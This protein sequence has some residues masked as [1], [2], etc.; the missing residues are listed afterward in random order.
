MARSFILFALFL[1]ERK[2]LAIL[3]RVQYNSKCK[4]TICFVVDLNALLIPGTS[5]CGIKPVFLGSRDSQLQPYAL[6][7]IH[8]NHTKRYD[9]S[10]SSVNCR[11]NQTASSKVF[12]TTSTICQ[13]LDPISCPRGIWTGI[14][15][16][17]DYCD[18]LPTVNRTWPQMVTSI[19]SRSSV[20]SRCLSIPN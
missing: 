18:L 15:I 19:P 17:Y 8:I 3:A 4:F 14:D 16:S 6:W 10:Y 9:N 7:K 2:P 13:A 11:V 1:L 20:R 5:L 12:S